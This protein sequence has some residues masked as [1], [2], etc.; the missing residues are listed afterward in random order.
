MKKTPKYIS[1]R[2]VSELFLRNEHQFIPKLGM[3]KSLYYLYF[4]RC[5]LLSWQD[6]CAVSTRASAKVTS[7]LSTYLSN[8]KGKR[9]EWKR[10]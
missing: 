8:R 4:S 7:R 2:K 6:N 10:R 3:A 5:G 9:F 1:D